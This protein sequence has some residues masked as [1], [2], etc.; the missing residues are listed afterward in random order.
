[1]KLN[2]SVEKPAKSTPK[3]S[4][5]NETETI[6]NKMRILKL[7]EQVKN[8]IEE[9]KGLL[10]QKTI[11]QKEIKD[12]KVKLT[13]KQKSPEGK[14]KHLHYKTSQSEEM[15]IQ[16]KH[17]IERLKKNTTIEINELIILKNS[18][19]K[20]KESLEAKLNDLEE[21]F[22]SSQ[23]IITT[24]QEEKKRIEQENSNYQ[25]EHNQIYSR[26]DLL[27]KDHDKLSETS[28]EYIKQISL[29][30]SCIKRIKG[31]LDNSN[32]SNLFSSQE[33]EIKLLRNEVE[34]L[35]SRENS[36]QEKFNEKLL[37]VQNR[38]EDEIK[39]LRI[40]NRQLEQKMN[41][42]VRRRENE[43]EFVKIIEEMKVKRPDGWT[44]NMRSWVFY[45]FSGLSPSVLSPSAFGY[46]FKRK[47]QFL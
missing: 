45:I 27:K 41:E 4:K 2:N 33:S 16:L 30:R 28:Q 36:N 3:N 6:K 23:N 11:L 34:E 7:E 46:Q 31:D 32:L 47:V 44:G 8:L 42:R 29:M 40:S 25:I 17:Q 15:V 13:S 18:I 37:M 12:L 20:E 5:A 21:S 1:M 24:L 39:A 35:T 9:N 19:L 10:S 26:Y 43:S 38:Y 22:N 14:V